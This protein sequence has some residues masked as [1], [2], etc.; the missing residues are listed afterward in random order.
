MHDGTA[1]LQTEGDKNWLFVTHSR[2]WKDSESIVINDFC[3][4][5]GAS[6]GAGAEQLPIQLSSCQFSISPSYEHFP[7]VPCFVH[8]VDAKSL[9]LER[10]LLFP[11]SV[12]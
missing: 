10:G 11:I 9:Y 1:S 7:P 2:D 12:L 6:K 5:T 3:T 8:R 4:K